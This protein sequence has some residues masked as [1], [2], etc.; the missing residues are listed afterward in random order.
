MV[1]KVSAPTCSCGYALLV[2]VVTVPTV[3]YLEKLVAQF[4]VGLCDQ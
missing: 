1:A 4:V 2:T 3:L